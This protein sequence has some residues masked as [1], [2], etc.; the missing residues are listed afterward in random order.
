MIVFNETFFENKNIKNWIK[1]GCALENDF[2][3]TRLQWSVLKG[4]SW[5]RSLK[6]TMSG[7]EMDGLKMDHPIS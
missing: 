2:D 3:R 6:F 1:T 7:L 4:P 5:I